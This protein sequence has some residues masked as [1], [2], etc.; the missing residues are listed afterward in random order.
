MDDDLEL[1]EREYCPPL[2]PALVRAICLDFDHTDPEQLSRVRELLNSIK[3]TAVEEQ[4]T[5]FDPSGSSGG[6]TRSSPGKGSSSELESNTESNVSYSTTTEPIGLSKDLSTLSLSNRSGSAS[7]DSTEAAGGF[8]DD[9][10]LLDTPTKELR[11][12]ETFPTLR[13]SFVS[14]TLKKCSGNF[15][16]ATD[17]LLNH[18]YFEDSPSTPGEEPAIAKGVDAFFEEHTVVPRG[19]KGKGKNKRNLDIH[20]RS[21][22]SPET[23]Q[24]EQINRWHETSRDVDFISTRTNTSMKTIAS[25]Y[26]KN[27]ASVSAT[28]MALVEANIKDHRDAQVDDPTVL[29][30]AIDLVSDFPSIELHHSIALIRLT[31]PSTAF[32]HELAKALKT[33]GRNASNGG[34]QVIPRYAPINLSD[35]T[36][37][38]PLSMS[39]TPS[40]AVPPSTSF[41]SA[42][43]TAAFAQAQA[44]HRKGKSDNLMK[45]AA[46]YYSQLG[47]DYD[48]ALK[49]ASAA[50][51]DALVAAQSS[52]TILDLHGVSVKDATRIARERVTAWW[53]MLGEAR[54]TSGGRNGI[55]DGYRIVTGLGRHSEGGRAKL[56]PAV[57][58]MLVREGWKVE[59][60]SGEMFV[61][62]VAAR[63]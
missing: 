25:L 11:L 6:A 31:H 30:N 26:H 34:I 36:P 4:F 48:A 63:R 40:Y 43:R 5:E 28:I 1:L 15:S 24:A 17:V 50:D 27:G 20:A 9:A 51:A 33:A 29:Q 8:F 55:G 10:E 22:S 52:S 45:A 44:A 41:L 53:H 60:G 54:I 7:E 18:V 58:K 46:G 3:Q 59:V 42:A 13:P 56:G 39:S 38:T 21:A 61:T 12:A 23:S 57:V 19:R 32:A 62:G 2:D 16:K 37:S 47:R 49:A 14:F 35:P